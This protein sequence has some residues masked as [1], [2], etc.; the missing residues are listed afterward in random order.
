ME[1]YS[2]FKQ[3]ED[4]SGKNDKVQIISNYSDNK[5]FIH[6]LKFLYDD[7]ITTGLSKKK[8]EK[9][10]NTKDGTSFTNQ[11]WGTPYDVMDFLTKNNTGSDD[12]I[13]VVQ[14][15][16]KQQQEAFG[17]DY[18]EWLKQVFTK[19]YKCGITSSSVNKAVPSL[20][21]EFKVQLAHPYEKFSDRIISTFYITKK[22][23]G[24]RTLVFIDFKD[25]KVNNVKFRTRKGHEILGLN[26]IKEDIVKGL[27]SEPFMN[28]ESIVLDGEI[29]VLDDI[30]NPEAV[31]SSTSKIIRKDGDKSGLKFQVFDY[32]LEREF[33]SGKSE[34]MYLERRGVVETMF[35]QCFA[36]TKHIVGVPALY[37]GD[38]KSEIVKW[39]NKATELGWEGVMVN[40]AHG[41]YETKRTPHLLKVKKFHSV[42]E[43]CTDVF[44]GEGKYE[45]SLGGIYIN[46]KGSTVGVGTG[47]TDQQRDYYWSNPDEIV[48]KIVEVKYFE[49]TTN[50]KD[51]SLSLRFPVFQSVREDKGLEDIS[52]D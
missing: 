14:E 27:N 18:A 25:N 39:S 28:T 17:E 50:Q 32:L 45:G 26:E 23:D 10:L 4:T 8:I 15:F 47:F 31:F 21:P 36:N 38:D 2:I 13:F 16:L 12:N 44:E 24:H 22:L 6:T 42:D 1:V 7:M 19:S 43:L 30:N 49:E 20:I 35:W 11:S 34:L 40:T 41:L 5:E 46:Y 51:D 48:G 3:I 33:W 37:V 52:Y 29:T 9:K